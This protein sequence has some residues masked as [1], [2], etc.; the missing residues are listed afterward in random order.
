MNRCIHMTLVVILLCTF[1][2][3][4]KA[5]GQGQP[6][7]NALLFRKLSAAFQE[8]SAVALG[9]DAVGTKEAVAFAISTKFL[10]TSLSK[11]FAD[12]DLR[13]A[14][15]VPPEV[16]PIT[17]P[18]VLGTSNLTPIDCRTGTFPCKS[19]CTSDCSD[20]CQAENA[21]RQLYSAQQLALV[22]YPA[23][24]FS[25]NVQ[26]RMATLQ[27][28]ENLKD[29]Q[30]ACDLDE[31]GL[32]EGTATSETDRRFASLCF[33]APK[34]VPSTSVLAST[35]HKSLK[36]SL[37]VS[38]RGEAYEVGVVVPDRIQTININATAFLDTMFRDPVSWMNCSLPYPLEFVVTSHSDEFVF[39]REV[40]L[41]EPQ[42]LVLASVH[43]GSYGPDLSPR[44]YKSALAFFIGPTATKAK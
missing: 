44:F 42:P 22:R 43:L 27:F 8:H 4:D 32:M 38:V 13:I 25:A 40:A 33:P 19:T 26:A 15:Q 10:S 2:G 36:A 30:I 7:T 18:S 5:L 23:V 21:I 3:I 11:L 29:A 1:G 39:H 12:S 17:K 35:I 41:L 14:L 24:S 34:I 28:A 16:V 6:N 9:D 20:L 31:H 37:D